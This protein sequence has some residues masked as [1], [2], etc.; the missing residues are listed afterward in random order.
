[1]SPASQADYAKL[2]SYNLK[3]VHMWAAEGLAQTCY[4]TY[5]DQ[6][7]GLGP[8]EIIVFSTPDRKEPNKQMLGGQRWIYALEKWKAAGARETPPGL[9]R[10]EPVVYSEAER[11]SGRDSGTSEKDYRLIK[12]GYLLRPEVS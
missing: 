8:D 2:A 6:P 9:A 1:M 5:A 7:A 11:K 3:D 10:N 12:P 4:L